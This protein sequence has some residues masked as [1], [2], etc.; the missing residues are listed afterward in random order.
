MNSLKPAGIFSEI[1]DL[2]EVD[3]TNRYALDTGRPGVLVR[4]R[5]QTS[6][7]GTRGRR[8]FSPHGENLY[9]TATLAPPQDRFPIIAGIAARSAIARIVPAAAITLKWPNDIVVSGRKVCGILCETRAGLTAIGVGINVNQ[10]VW[11]EEL[12]RMAVSLRQI[13]GSAFDLD[14]VAMT[15]A[16]ER[17]TWVEAYYTQGFSPV[18]LEFLE[19]GL[20]RDY[21][22]FDDRQRPCSIIDLTMDGHLVIESEGSRR[23][24]VSESISIGWKENP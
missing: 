10:T 12:E 20:L 9:M 13:T 24:L 11:P 19:H 15:V 23:S 2:E 7:R 5:M 6:G 21:E 8:W 14:E 22:V 4:A 1:I 16:G 17:S 18:R 3:S